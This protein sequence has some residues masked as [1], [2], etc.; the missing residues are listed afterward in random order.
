MQ[1]YTM[2]KADRQRERPRNCSS[3]HGNLWPDKVA[4]DLPPSDGLLDPQR[5]LQ[6]P[7]SQNQMI[8]HVECQTPI[9]PCPE[10]TT[11]F[12]NP[13]PLFKSRDAKSVSSRGCGGERERHPVSSREAGRFPLPWQPSLGPAKHL[14]LISTG[15]AR[16][17]GRLGDWA[18]GSETGR[19]PTG[20]ALLP[21]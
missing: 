15:G 19:R 4:T 2:R 21:P 8:Q 11:R 16:R 18:A 14:Y 1:D 9:S 10:S 6:G 20:K 7:N 12:K 17:P 3:N 13:P 5:W